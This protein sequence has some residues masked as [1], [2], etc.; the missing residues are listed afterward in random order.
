MFG[1]AWIEARIKTVET[2]ANFC[3][4]FFPR[5]NG[6]KNKK[7]LFSLEFFSRVEE[8]PSAKESKEEGGKKTKRYRKTSFQFP[9]FS[10]LGLVN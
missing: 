10:Q 3:V 7:Q 1:W 8:R 5:G 9:V 2:R 4:R 6:A